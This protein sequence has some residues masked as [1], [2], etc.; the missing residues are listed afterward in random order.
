MRAVLL[1]L[2]LVVAAP[3]L[4]H[5]ATVSAR[6]NCD[7]KA[8]GVCL[9]EV[10]VSAD[11][12]EANALEIRRRAR[13]LR[14]T[15]HGAP[16]VAGP[17]CRA[18]G[19]HTARC[20][21]GDLTLGLGDGDDV[22]RLRGARRPLDEAA[23]AE[24]ADRLAGFRR[25]DGGPGDDRLIGTRAGDEL[26]GGDGRDRLSGRAGDDLLSGDGEGFV[27][28]GTDRGVAADVL[29]GG[30]G[31]DV[32]LY[33][34]SMPIRVN[35]SDPG[36]DG[37]PG[38]GDRLAGIDGA[39]GGVASD[40]L[41]GDDGPNVLLGGGGGDRVECRGGDDLAGG[42]RNL[43]IGCERLRLRGSRR[44]LRPVPVRVSEG[45]V[46]LRLPCGRGLRRNGRR[47]PCDVV[48][49]VA[50]PP[51]QATVIRHR[52]RPGGGRVAVP[53]GFASEPLVVS[54][55]YPGSPSGRSRASWVLPEGGRG[56]G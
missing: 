3:S 10:V 43:L 40:T 26:W 31:T 23:G 1:S 5:A 8:A 44:G 52:L 37:E 7:R 21:N 9:I 24:G 4:A 48:V 15:D 14:V 32:A 11:P 16:L 36:P 49:T 35:L 17:G 22:A 55:R 45:R 47:G 2:L 12:G 19:R 30:G 50:Q 25:A 46:E 33:A 38:E 54:L 6:E 20:I 51:G 18:S 28:T 41:I 13:S 42:P 53:S 34:R 39:R 29:E 27:Q 56:G